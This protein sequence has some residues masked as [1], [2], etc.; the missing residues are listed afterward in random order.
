MQKSSSLPQSLT[1]EEDIVMFKVIQLTA[2]V[3]RN[4]ETEAD[5]AMV[6]CT[7]RSVTYQWAK[8]NDYG[9]LG[10]LLGANDAQRVVLQ[11]T[12]LHNIMDH[13]FFLVINDDG[14]PVTYTPYCVNTQKGEEVETCRYSFEKECE[15]GAWILFRRV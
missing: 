13:F 1:P 10:G 11:N 14:Y 5:F 2:V 9:P 12:A 6:W 7:D 8:K 3:H 15:E 4:E